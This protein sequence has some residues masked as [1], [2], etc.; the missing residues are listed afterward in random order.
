MPCL[1]QQ[2]RLSLKNILFATDFSDASEA[3]VPYALGLARR[4]GST[5]LVAHVIPPEVERSIP[6]GAMPKGFDEARF[7]AEQAMTAFLGCTFLS[8]AP[9]EVLLDKGSIAGRICQMVRNRQIDLVVIG[10]RGRRL[11]KFDTDSI[12]EEIFRTVPCPVLIVGPE[13]TQKELAKAALQRIVYLTDFSTRSLEALPYAV[14]FAQDNEALL[15][16]VHVAVETTMG[17]FYYGDS[18]SV[19]FRNGSRA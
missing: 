14:A 8:G 17:P 16:F 12:A 13:V 18:R 19:A 5:I 10:T 3:A 7:F 11:R 15:T 2:T 6:P 4:Y 9:H 1:E